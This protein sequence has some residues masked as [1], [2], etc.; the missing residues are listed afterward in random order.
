VFQVID[1][2]ESDVDNRLV[3]TAFGRRVDGAVV[4]ADITGFRPAFLLKLDGAS[5]LQKYNR[6]V[7]DIS[8]AHAGKPG[9]V[10]E[11]VQR[12]DFMFYSECEKRFL[13]VE[14]NNI[15]DFVTTR[16][17]FGKTPAMKAALY[18]SKNPP[19]L[20]M[21]H[22]RGL[23]TSGWLEVREWSAAAPDDAADGRVHVTADW[24]AVAKCAD[25]PAAMAPLKVAAFDIE[26]T[27]SHG[28][29]P[30]PVKGYEKTAREVVIW[31]SDEMKRRPHEQV[32]DDLEAKFMGAF[33]A[34]AAGAG[35]PASGVSRVFAKDDVVVTPDAY[36][37]FIDN[38]IRNVLSTKVSNTE[39]I[40]S[41][42][43]LL[44][45][46]S[47]QHVLPRLQGDPIIQIGLTVNEV[48]DAR[49]ARYVFVVG[50]CDAVPDTE[51]HSYRTEKAMLKGFVS[52]FLEL[53]P[54]VVTGYNIMGFD[55]EYIYRRAGE[56]SQDLVRFLEMG[57]MEPE[58]DERNGV[59]VEHRLSS[60]ALGDNDLRYLHMPGRLLIDLMKVI[61]RDH[62]LDSYTLNA[63]SAAFIGDAKDDI[64]PGDIFRLHAGD[65]ADRAKI[66]KYCVQDCA[67]CNRL[68]EKLSTVAGSFGMAEVCSVP[69]SW[70]FL[71]GQGAK[72]LSLVSVQCA[73]DNYA[74]PLLGGGEKGVKYEG[75]LV[76]EPATGIYMDDP[77]V[78]LDFS[79]LY[80]SS[81][82]ATNMSHDTLVPQG[83]AGRILVETLG[84]ETSDVTFDE[85]NE[86]G[87]RVAKTVR[88]VKTAT[89][90][91]LPRILQYLLS[92]R[93]ATRARIKGCTDPFERGVLDGLQL[94]YKLTA[95]SLYGQLGA[96]TSPI[97]CVDIAAS[98]TAVG[99]SMITQLK[100]FVEADFGGDVV[101]GD[102]DSCFM[103][104][105]RLCVDGEGRKLEGRAAVAKC[106]E[107]GQ[108][109]SAEFQKLIPDP[110][111]AEYEKTFWP[112]ILLSK[113]R[114][115]RPMDLTGHP[116]RSIWFDSR[117]LATWRDV[118]TGGRT[119]V[120]RVEVRDERRQGA[121][122]LVDGHRD[123][124]EG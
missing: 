30:V 48:G 43:A 41:V 95:N 51:T 45:M 5:A 111:C 71:R 16:A 46:C 89:P 28:D 63:V 1:W 84:V 122:Q 116:C 117:P 81:M 119:Q 34:P 7:R 99:R 107:L 79:S 105:P 61:Q 19:F 103:K 121:R 96:S 75:A 21:I 65:D 35:A 8:R 82:I 32:L 83:E 55:F 60:S 94:A 29:F 39:K 54:D 123:E 120:C 25:P 36:R 69:T 52:K 11:V 85:D 74:I 92:Q 59:Y 62:K 98:T 27:S 49:V 76:L 2:Y 109:C 124:A 38:D 70:I 57:R 72:V 50:G 114:C 44:N 13:K 91:I 118:L 66:A 115:A 93:K 90:G 77:I 73:R 58:R 20:Q 31:V 106:I 78:V 86:H 47:N 64:T 3:V 23:S 33:A 56:I 100:T 17:R 10:G 87:V 9:N 15:R 67:L 113:K 104:F 18:D 40:E 26:C 42:A 80:P 110:Q 53:D 22:A 108:R 102:T 12:K 4:R 97:C 88:F 68:C 112:F 24:R 101:Y 37:K 6:A 14:F